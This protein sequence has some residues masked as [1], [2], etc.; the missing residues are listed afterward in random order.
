M[1]DVSDY[2]LQK[3]EPPPGRSAPTSRSPLP[4]I[5]LAAVVVAGGALFVYLQRDSSSVPADAV[6]QTEV[7]VTEV[8][9]PLGVAADPIALPPLD[10]S[11]A[12]V[13]DLVRAL[14]SHPRVAAWL[15]TSGLIRNFT[16]AVENIANGRTPAVHLRVL[17]PQGPF[18]VVEQSGA[19]MIDTRSYN[20]YNDLAAAVDSIDPDGA[21]ALYSTL[22]PRIEDAYRELGYDTSSAGT[23]QGRSLGF[24]RALEIAIIRLLEAPAPEGDLA[25]VPRGAL[26]QF[27]DARLERL[28]AAQKQLVR[29]GPR[30]VRTIQRTLR[31]IGLALGIREERLP[32]VSR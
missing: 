6:T 25:L 15:T 18:S 5:A 20:R 2:E 13:R 32:R 28:T 3:T 27:N 11:D 4:W 22:K 24:D 19:T 21:A 26:Y 8:Q 23:P 12:L 30:N 1:H 29:M 10:Q 14:S 16:V 31:A 7:P 17:R 9:P